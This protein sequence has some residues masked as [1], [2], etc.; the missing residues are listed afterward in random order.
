MADVLR[1]GDREVQ[2]AGIGL[3]VGDELRQCL[4]GSSRLMA[5]I[6]VP[7]PTL[8]IGTSCCSGSEMSFCNCGVRVIIDDAAKRM[9]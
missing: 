2:L 3:R 9:V 7:V 5:I 1:A 6:C 8:V 4:D